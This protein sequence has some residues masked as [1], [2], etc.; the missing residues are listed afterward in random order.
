M[1]EAKSYKDVVAF[2][3]TVTKEGRETVFPK[4]LGRAI[5][6]DNGDVSV[7]LDTIPIRG[8]DGSLIIQTPR[9]A[10]RITDENKDNI[11]F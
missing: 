2:I 10:T 11:P 1:A 7:Y 5:L 8:W 9:S 6:K 3:K 4:T